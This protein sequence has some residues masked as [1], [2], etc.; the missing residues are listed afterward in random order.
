MNDMDKINI[1]T[2]ENA[3][4]NSN[5][6]SLE[7][8]VNSQSDSIN[9][10]ARIIR[11]IEMNGSVSIPVRAVLPGTEKF[12]KAIQGTYST[13]LPGHSIS[14]VICRSG[15]DGH[16]DSSCTVDGLGPHNRYVFK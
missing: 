9:Q 16:S 10:I 6:D 11:A 5:I 4:L 12:L 8:I 14:Y 13:Y 1:L 15:V 7:K 3:Q 2:H